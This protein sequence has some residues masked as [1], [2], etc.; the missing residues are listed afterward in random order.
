MCF[1]KE[2]NKLLSSAQMPCLFSL[3]LHY[4]HIF[5]TCLSLLKY[6]IFFYNSVLT[7]FS[8]FPHL[9]RSH[10][11]FTTQLTWLFWPTP[12]V[13]EGSLTLNSVRWPNTQY[14][15]LVEWDWQQL[16][17]IYT[18]SWGRRHLMPGG[19]PHG[20]CTGE[21]NEPEGVVGGRLCCT[22]RGG[23]PLVPMEVGMWLVCWKSLTGL[24]E[25]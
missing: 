4:T 17:V 19:R 14:P 15:T 6:I 22:K 9:S 13:K 20:G 11:S 1:R 25:G 2:N 8:P 16:L 12:A 10:S 18:Y 24:A 21:Q 7:C 3:T 5:S 23:S